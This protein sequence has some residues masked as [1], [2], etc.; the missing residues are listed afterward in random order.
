MDDHIGLGLGV[1]VLPAALAFED[2]LQGV[3]RLASLH[4]VGDLGVGGGAHHAAHGGLVAVEELIGV[5]LVG[6]D[7]CAVGGA[8]LGKLGQAHVVIVDGFVAQLRGDIN[9]DV[10][11]VLAEPALQQLLQPAAVLVA[12]VLLG[13]ELQG[14]IIGGVA[15]LHAHHVV[16]VAVGVL[17]GHIFHS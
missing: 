4:V 1:V 14:G 5:I 6:Q 12:Q 10:E 15:A 2:A 13:L 11:M 17:N 9:A 7:A 3:L 8:V 16:D